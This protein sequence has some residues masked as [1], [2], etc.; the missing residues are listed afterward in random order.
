MTFVG[1]LSFIIS[2][3]FYRILLNNVPFAYFQTSFIFVV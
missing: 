3:C 2:A 1:V